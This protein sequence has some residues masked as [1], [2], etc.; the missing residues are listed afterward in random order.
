MLEPGLT[1]TSPRG[2][3]VEILEN[4]PERFAL[5]RI[6]PPGTGI[7]PRPRFVPKAR[8]LHAVVPPGS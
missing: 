8:G 6:L 2:T 3:V 4:T 7:E 1:V 5:K